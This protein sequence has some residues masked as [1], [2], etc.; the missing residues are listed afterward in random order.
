MAF[1][2]SM[3]RNL[4]EHITS[5]DQSFEFG[6]R[7]F[8]GAVGGVVIYKAI[9]KAILEDNSLNDWGSVGLTFITIFVA[10]FWLWSPKRNL[11][12]AKQWLSQSV[13]SRNPQSEWIM[14]VG[15]AVFFSM[16][17]LSAFNPLLYSIIFTIYGIIYFF[18]VTYYHKSMKNALK[19]CRKQVHNFDIE[20]ENEE[21]L[22]QVYDSAFGVLDHYHFEKPHKMRIVSLIIAGIIAIILSALQSDGREYFGF[23]ACLVAGLSLLVTEFFIIAWRSERDRKL[24]ALEVKLSEIH[25]KIEELSE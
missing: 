4:E 24:T 17:I 22:R 2:Y 3:S 14:I 11:H 20:N 21:D 10:F 15:I 7:I 23:L 9:E 25:E 1:K 5:L 12:I 18:G 19:K 16:L 6:K 13:S 8:F